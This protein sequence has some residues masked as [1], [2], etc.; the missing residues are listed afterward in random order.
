M[1]GELVTEPENALSDI[2][3]VRNNRIS[4]TPVTF[5]MTKTKIMGDLNSILCKH[6]SCEWFKSIK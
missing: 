4:I 2:A 3:S 5:E 6:D 1:A